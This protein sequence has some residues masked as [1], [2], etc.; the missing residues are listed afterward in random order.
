MRCFLSFA[1]AF[2]FALT[3][4]S[5]LVL[6]QNAFALQNEA[7]ADV[8]LLEKKYYADLELKEA[9][10]QVFAKTGGAGEKQASERIAANL[11]ALEEFTEK[12]YAGK[13]IIADVWFGSLSPG[14][15]K[16]ILEKTLSER[17]PSACRH[18][19]DFSAKTLDW[20]KKTAHKSV[21]L[22]FD[23]RISKLGFSHA[24]TSVEWVG[25]DVV[26]GATFFVPEKSFAWVSVM[27]EGFG[28]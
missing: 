21:E 1:L 8:L 14:E 3:L 15:E 28:K 19:F 17:K 18:C 6:R 10:G 20:D 2:F 24:P 9:F 11:E 22:M 12:N 13:G 26:F 16:E 4:L 7:S 5:L 27:R 23:G 25:G